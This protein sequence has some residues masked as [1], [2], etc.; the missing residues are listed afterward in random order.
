M[1]AKCFHKILRYLFKY[2]FEILRSTILDAMSDNGFFAYCFYKGGAQSYWLKEDDRQDDYFPDVCS[3]VQ[4]E[5]IKEISNKELEN[6]AYDLVIISTDR[7]RKILN[8][9]EKIYSHKIIMES[10][11][12]EELSNIAKSLGMDTYEIL[13]GLIINGQVKKIV[14]FQ[15]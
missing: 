3:I 4:S 11:E 8:M 9:N 13:D 1:E 7:L 14:L 12:S 15:E 5:D 6:V 2:D 10:D